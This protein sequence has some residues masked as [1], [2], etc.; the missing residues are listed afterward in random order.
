MPLKL[1]NQQRTNVSKSRG[2]TPEQTQGKL[3]NQTN[4]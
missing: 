2:K 1:L 4:I 3:Q